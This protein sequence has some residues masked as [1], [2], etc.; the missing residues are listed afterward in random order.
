MREWRGPLVIDLNTTDWSYPKDTPG[1]VRTER[2]KTFAEVMDLLVRNGNYIQSVGGSFSMHY[3]IKVQGKEG[4]TKEYG[5]NA[6][7]SA[8]RKALNDYAQHLLDVEDTAALLKAYREGKV[9][10]P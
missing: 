9:V 8:V 3:R 5:G 4:F 1:G 7:S 6:P 2:P 10:N